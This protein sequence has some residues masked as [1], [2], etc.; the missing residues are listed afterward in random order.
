MS[1][2]NKSHPSSNQSGPTM[3]FHE[4]KIEELQHLRRPPALIPTRAPGGGPPVKQ[5]TR[6]DQMFNAALD[7]QIAFWKEQAEKTQG[8]DDLAKNALNRAV[9]EGVQARK[10]EIRGLAKNDFA[11]GKEKDRAK[12]GFNRSSG[13]ER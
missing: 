9:R 1:D 8:Q 3:S 12:Q 7:R 4:R 6:E 5:Y 10:D 13:I 2:E 11:L